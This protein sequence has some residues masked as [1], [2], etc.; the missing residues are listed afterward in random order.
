MCLSDPNL[1]ARN[2]IGKR[3]IYYREDPNL[4]IRYLLEGWDHKDIIS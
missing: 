1:K 2:W 4:S 3:E